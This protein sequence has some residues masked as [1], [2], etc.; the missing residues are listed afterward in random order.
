MKRKKRKT[1]SIQIYETYE[2]VLYMKRNVSIYEVIK[3]H[4]DKQQRKKGI[5]THESRQFVNSCQP[6]YKNRHSSLPIAAF[7][8]LFFSISS[9]N[10]T[11]IKYQLHTFIIKIK[12][13][14][15]CATKCFLPNYRRMCYFRFVFSFN[16][17]IDTLVFESNIYKLNDDL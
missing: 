17:Y 11:Q 12:F 7:W 4:S 16:F 14:F 5:V 10:L 2:V 6:T 3:T 1:M 15:S 8:M 9:L 13:F